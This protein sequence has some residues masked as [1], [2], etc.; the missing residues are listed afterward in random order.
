MSADERGAAC[1]FDLMK[2]RIA[3]GDCPDRM[4]VLIDSLEMSVSDSL[5]R[6]LQAIETQNREA[7]ISAIH[8][9]KGTLAMAGADELSAQSEECIATAKASTDWYPTKDRVD[10]LRE[11][12][13]DAMENL[14]L[15]ANRNEAR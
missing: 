6:S 8:R 3:S 15:E 2:L 4:K 9:L 7:L 11:L 1:H 14:Q 13:L 12:V 5:E 10:R